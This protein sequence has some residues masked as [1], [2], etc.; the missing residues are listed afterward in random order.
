MRKRSFICCHVRIFVMLSFFLSTI[1]LQD[2]ARNCVDKIVGNRIPMG[3]NCAPLVAGLILFYYE[4]DFMLSLSDSNQADDI[5][6]FN[7]TS[8]Y[9]DDLLNSDNPYFEQTVSQIH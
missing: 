4:R 1:Y 6:A 2:L 8:R 3:T 7:F 9:L 5:E